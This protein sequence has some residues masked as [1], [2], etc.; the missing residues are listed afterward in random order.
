VH[1]TRYVALDG[2]VTVALVS[3]VREHAPT[4][5]VD[6]SRRGI[7]ATENPLLS[8][9][10]TATSEVGVADVTAFRRISTIADKAA[11]EREKR[12]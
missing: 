5:G 11:A 1:D 12:A 4:V 3:V 6:A 10:T 9:R 2:D 8:R 7:D